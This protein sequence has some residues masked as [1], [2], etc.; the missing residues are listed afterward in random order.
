ML[1]LFT[2][3]ITQHAVAASIPE[4]AIGFLFNLP[5]PF[6]RIM[7]LGPTQPL[8]EMS[9]KNLPGAVKGGRRV[10]LTTSPPSVSRLF[11]NLVDVGASTSHNPLG[12]HG[13]L[14]E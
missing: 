6:S 8:K 7:T 5:N 12:L 13:L 1:K 9:T 11:S 3:I 10:R 4:E 2:S 14:Q